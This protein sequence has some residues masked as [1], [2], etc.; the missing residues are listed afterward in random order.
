MN[1]EN[2]GAK[3]P[4]IGADTREFFLAKNVEDDSG[5]PFVYIVYK[6]TRRVIQ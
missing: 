2:K 1:G 3:Q 4:N 5:T 6:F